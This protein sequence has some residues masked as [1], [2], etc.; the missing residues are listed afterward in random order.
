MKI[1]CSA[2]ILSLLWFGPFSSFGHAGSAPASSSNGGYISNLQ[3]D[4]AVRVAQTET[5]FEDSG[6]E[7]PPQSIPDPF[8]PINRLFFLF[9][10]R[11]YFWFAKPVASVYGSIVPESVR[12]SVRNF[13]SNT[14]TPIRL[15]NCLLQ[16]NFKGAGTEFT[17]F[18]LNTT[19][20]MLGFFDPAKNRFNIEKT[21]EDFGQTLGFYGIGPIFYIDWPLLGP[22]TLR[23][24]AGFVGDMFLDPWAHL[25]NSFPEYFT[26]GI[27][28]RLNSTSL[29]LGTYE[30]LK[31]AALDPYVAMRDAYYQF[32]QTRIEQ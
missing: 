17:R 11:F 19:I 25:V 5:D 16:A 28:N 27:Y 4:P 3:R 14:A 29:T 18:V 10:D 12:V 15:A 23:D 26:V 6:L 2:L 8:E 21:D 32:R 22:S 1:T 30:D 24:T 7:E 31:E 20:G 9:N 13:F